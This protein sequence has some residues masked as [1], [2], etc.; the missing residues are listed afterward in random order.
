MNDPKVKKRMAHA[1]K[2]SQVDVDKYD[3]IFYVGGLGPPRDLP[4]DEDN[5]RVSTEVG[6]LFLS[7]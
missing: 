4:Y 3:G 2:L 1:L 5:K 7:R 6:I